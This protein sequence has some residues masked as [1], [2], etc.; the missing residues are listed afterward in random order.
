MPSPSSLPPSLMLF[1]PPSFFCSWKANNQLSMQI[2]LFSTGLP[3]A[4]QAATTFSN[5]S[6]AVNISWSSLADKDNTVSRSSPQGEDSDTTLV[7]TIPFTPAVPSTSTVIPPSGPPSPRSPPISHTLHQQDAIIFT[8][9]LASTLTTSHVHSALGAT[10]KW[11]PPPPTNSVECILIPTPASS[12]TGMDDRS[13][14]SRI[15]PPALI[16][17]TGPSNSGSVILAW[18]FTSQ[19]T[20]HF[21]PDCLHHCCPF[22][23]WTAPGHPNYKC[24]EL[25]CS[26]CEQH[27][28]SQILYPQAM[29]PNYDPFMDATWDLSHYKINEGDKSSWDGTSRL[30]GG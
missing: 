16:I 28:H 24:P 19:S 17:P 23:R 11:C 8:A 3:Q 1:S 14:S 27:G 4:Y 10:P 26:H 9:R 18:C 2:T 15:I 20:K 30:Q 7:P 21:H 13:H 22:C 25:H 6:L 12:I 5:S 29:S